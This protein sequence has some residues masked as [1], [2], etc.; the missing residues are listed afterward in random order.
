MKDFFKSVKRRIDKLDAE[1]LREQYGRISDEVLLLENVLKTIKE[2]VVVL[3]GRGDVVFENEAVRDILGMDADAAIPALNMPLG[4]VSKK[5]LAITYPNEK[6]IE[7]QTIPMKDN[8][9]LV[10][11]DVTSERQRTEKELRAGATQAVRDL[12]SG[13]AHEIGNPLNAISLNLQ[14]LK[15]DPSGASEIVDECQAQIERLDGILK[16]F[17]QALR[18]SRPDLKPGNVADPLTTCLKTLKAQ[19]EERRIALTLDIP[20]TLPA[21]A[22]DK[23]QMEQVF[24]NLLKNALEAIPD[25][26]HIDIDLASDDNDVIVSIR[27]DGAGMTEAQVANLFEPYKTSKKHGT[28]LGLMITRRII[29]DH[30]GTIAVQSAPGDGTEFTLRLPRLERRIRAL[31]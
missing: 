14:L 20:G 21:V 6:T 1:H 16:G 19:L 22:L 25:G 28:G 4:V 9:V 2:A 27:D 23:A 15:R 18:P 10:L 12:A 13:V 5:E 29:H 17:L 30:G 7:V 24:F 3:D 11:R 31:K 26:G 8:T